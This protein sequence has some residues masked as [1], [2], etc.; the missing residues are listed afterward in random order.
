[1]T[2]ANFTV[3]NVPMANFTHNPTS[4]K[5]L[6]YEQLVF[7]NTGLINETHTLKASVS[8]LNREIWISFDYALYTF[9]FFFFNVS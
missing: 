4:S 1:M 9:V 8:G 2:V 3:D 7:S 6:E 5:D